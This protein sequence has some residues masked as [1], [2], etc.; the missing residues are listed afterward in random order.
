VKAMMNTAATHDAPRMLTSF[1]NPSKYKYQAKPNDNPKYVTGIPDEE[2]YQRVKL[3]LIHQFTSLGAPQIWN[4]DELGMT[5]GDDPDCRKPLWW[6]EYQFE[7]EYRNNFQPGV[8]EYDDVGFNQEHLDFYKKIIR[9]RKAEPVLVDGDFEFLFAE[10]NR[11]A[12]KRVDDSEE[13]I[14]L[15]NLGENEYQYSL[16]DGNI[17]NDLLDGLDTQNEVV[18]P[19]LSA[20]ILKKVRN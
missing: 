18:V 11:L 5:G 16:P 14:V 13:I 9:I 15:F 19:A 2:V 7:P 4:G 1:A 6:P 17:Y 8:K 10:G 20:K 12:Y 3:Y